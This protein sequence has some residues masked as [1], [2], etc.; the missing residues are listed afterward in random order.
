MQGLSV[1]TGLAVLAFWGFVAAVS[2]AGIWDGIR[3]REARHETLRRLLDNGESLDPA[4]RDRLLA[5]V[6]DGG[7]RDR[8]LKVYGLVTLC[9]APGVALLGWLV[10]L[11]FPEWWLP[12]LGAAILIACVAV[13]LLV[14]SAA[15]ARWTNES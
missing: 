14:A 12:L 9:T 5:M 10:G 4:L 3:K 8:D 2:V 6:G 1:G 13:G 11:G 7:R 15:A